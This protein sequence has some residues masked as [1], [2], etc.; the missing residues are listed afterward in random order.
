M[1][2]SLTSLGGVIA[3][4]VTP[5]DAERDEIRGDAFRANLRAH[6]AQGLAG[7]L[8]TGSTGEAALLDDTERRQL[9]E[10]ARAVVPEDRWLL[11]GVGSESTRQTIARA[12]DAAERGADAVLVVAPHYY[13]P[14]M[15]TDALAAHYRRVA[16]ASP[17]P[18]LLYNIPKYMH[19]ALSPELVHALAAHGNIVGIKDSAGD[20]ERLGG[21]LEAQSAHFTVLTGH[22]GTVYAA[23]EMGA[24]G[25]ILAVSLFAG[26]L[27]LEL[28]S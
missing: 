7:V 24:K 9:V 14:A 16:D 25:G 13:G 4:V 17:V 22:A 28:W 19:F 21:Y 2:P 3:P 1:A 5:F 27:T 20:L 12:R 23:L 18:V 11:A 26:A 10:W 6:L 8:V 15:T